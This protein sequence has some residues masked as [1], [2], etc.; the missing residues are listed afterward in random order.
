MTKQIMRRQPVVRPV[1]GDAAPEL[2]LP[3]ETGATFALSEM[4]GFPTL[5]SFLSHAA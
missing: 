4:R 5:V 3:T 2:N 1:V